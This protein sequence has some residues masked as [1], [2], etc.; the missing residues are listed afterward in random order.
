M[1]YQLDK[2]LG[3]ICLTGVVL[4]CYSQRLTPEGIGPTSQYMRCH[5]IALCSPQYAIA[6]LCL[7]PQ[8]N[9]CCWGSWKH[10]L[11]NLHMTFIWPWNE[12]TNAPKCLGRSN[13]K[14]KQMTKVPNCKYLLLWNNQNIIKNV[15][16]CHFFLSFS[17]CIVIQ[18]LY[19]MHIE[20]I[21]YC[22]IVCC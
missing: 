14:G 7:Q 1:V 2:W 19:L 17:I 16:F 20:S 12:N 21:G 13:L 8:W 15:F 3:H 10:F 9:R 4:L 5:T 11:C 18:W 22:I 6:V